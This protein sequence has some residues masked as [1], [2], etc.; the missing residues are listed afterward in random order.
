[1][2]TSYSDAIRQGFEYLLEKYPD[3]FIFGQGV[4][5]PWYVGNTMKDLDEKFGRDRVIDSPVSE[6]ACTGA[7]VGASLFGMR[8][9]VIH[10]RMDFMILATDPLVNQAAKWGHMLGGAAY[11]R[12]TVRSIINRGGEQGAQHSQ[13]LHSW[14]AHVPG[15]KVVMPGTPKDARDLLI[16]AVLSNDPVLYIDDRWLYETKEDIGEI[17]EIE[18]SSIKPQVLSHGSDITIVGSGYSTF[19]AQ[20]SSTVLRQ[21]GVTAEVIDLRL[22][23]PFNPEAIIESVKKTGRL[24]CIDGGWKTCGMAGEVIASVVEKLDPSFLKSTPQR[25]TLPD[26]PAPTSSVLENVYYPSVEQIVTVA[27]ELVA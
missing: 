25:I 27:K 5:S 22:L 12:L 19:L 10:P 14:Y 8:P 23:N 16:A 15:L 20:E 1:M 9:I 3:V 24:L 26:C 13:A 7:A 11:P 21:D 4:W 6:W 18:L 2:K 17:Q